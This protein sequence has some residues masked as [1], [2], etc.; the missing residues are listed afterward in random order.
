[1]RGE[2]KPFCLLLWKGS[3]VKTSPVPECTLVSLLGSVSFIWGRIM[4]STLRFDHNEAFGGEHQLL[5]SHLVLSR[6]RSHVTDKEPIRLRECWLCN[7]YI[8]RHVGETDPFPGRQHIP[9]WPLLARECG[10]NDS[11]CNLDLPHFLRRL[12]RKYRATQCCTSPRLLSLTCPSCV[13]ETAWALH[14][15]SGIDQQSQRCPCE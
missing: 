3:W 1:M 12:G 10:E 7:S 2:F 5:P 9:T 6:P 8:A 11:C 14:Y 15:W 13:C 4:D